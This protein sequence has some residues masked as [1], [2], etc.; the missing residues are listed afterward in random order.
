M[1]I[2]KPFAYNPSTSFSIG[3]GFNALVS[4]VG[5]QSD[6]KIMVGG[7]F[8]GFSGIS[9]N[10]LI[11]LNTDGSKDETFDIGSGFNGPV[12]VTEFQSDG[13]VLVGGDF[14]TFTGSTQNRLVRLNSD[15]SKDTSFDIGSGFGSSYGVFAITIQSDG[16]ILVGGNFSTYK[17]ST[18]NSLIRLNSD[19][20]KDTSFDIGSGFIYFGSSADINS[21]SIQND[22]K[23]IVGG[24]FTQFTG[25]SQNRLIRLN[26][27]GSKDS[28]F[29]IGSGFDNYVTT[30]AIQS[31]GK[32]L[33]G[34]GFTT[35]TGS[36][37]NNLIRLNSNGSKDETFN[38]GS[39]FDSEVN[40][41]AVQSDGKILAGG[42][43]TTFT[44][45]T[46]NKL[47]RLNSDG[48]KDTSFNIGSG[49]NGGIYNN[50]VKIQSDE[51]ILAGGTFTEYTGSSQNRLIK[52]NSDGSIFS[53]GT[54]PTIT[55]T[56][57]Y[58]DI[59]VGD[60]Q[61]DY[62]IN[63]GGVK[64]WGGPNEELGYVVG[65][66]RPNGQP[67]PVGAGGPAYV[68]F[69][70][71]ELLTDNSFLNL[72][73]YIGSENSEPPFATTSD[74]VTWL[75]DNGYYTSYVAL[76][77]AAY[78]IG[79]LFTTFSGT[80][81]SQ[82]IKF[83]S[84]NTKDET[85]DVGTGFNGPIF[86]ISNQSDGKILAGG[87]YTQF[88]GSSQNYLIRLN[89]D[90]S[91]DETFVSVIIDAVNSIAIQSD[92][93]I[94][95]GGWFGLKRVNSDGTNDSTFDIGSGFNNGVRSIPIQSDGKILVGG[96]YTTYKD[97]TQNSLI[98]LNSD[99]SK[100]TSFDIGTGFGGDGYA[101]VDSM[102]IQSD[103]KILVGGQFTQYSGASQNYLIRL[104]SDGSK[105][106]TFDI[107]SGFNGSVNSMAIQSDGKILVG[108]WFTQ[109]TGTSQNNLI[110][111]NSDGSKDESFNIGTGFSSV[112]SSAVISI[113]IQSDGTILVGGEFNTYNG[114]STSYGAILN[115]DGSLN[116]SLNFN[117]GV[118][119]IK[120]I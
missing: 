117:G 43:F 79:G 28:T 11:R 64:W 61:R 26:T 89:S 119:S 58:G 106:S 1:A 93:K 69:W 59:I 49:F 104:N 3:S 81:A 8:D 52:L 102:A 60:I 56:T 18:Q 48:S 70:R 57:Q 76:P 110:R 107:G 88:T 67:A 5:F 4:S 94:L 87:N 80:N 21:I 116:S 37:Q 120:I 27:D 96:Y 6:G 55:G 22:G 9:Q 2:S 98:R 34:G 46:Q 47:I 109:F 44:G 118:F 50:T 35:F 111:L 74:A 20:S 10:R 95:V 16:K 71:S 51:K 36:T 25:S 66:A 90:G 63:Y 41:V 108:G 77:Q 82:L 45:S 75:N 91:K 97:L 92:G 53:G 38:I 115:S 68:G 17:D 84:S 103:G 85:F 100:D 7:D 105:D 13:K 83:N 62:S 12:Y 39:G 114:L 33:V 65:N 101:S 32:I 54:A 14:T 31:N 99:G 30:I 29:N 72:A 24:S 15:G 113:A 40:S 19:G 86:S 78:Y 42:Y 112:Y 73:N 23:I